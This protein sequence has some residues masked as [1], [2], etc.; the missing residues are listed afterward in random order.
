MYLYLS[1]HPCWNNKPV[2][3]LPHMGLLLLDGRVMSYFAISDWLDRHDRV[4]P[5]KL[6][7]QS[8]LERMIVMEG[9][10][11]WFTEH[12]HLPHERLIGLRRVRMVS[13][14]R[15]DFTTGFYNNRD[16]ARL[17]WYNFSNTIREVTLSVLQSIRCVQRTWRKQMAQRFRSARL[18]RFEKIRCFIQVAQRLLSNDMTNKIRD[19]YLCSS[20]EFFAE[21]KH[22]QPISRIETNEFKKLFG[23]N[24]STPI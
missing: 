23:R 13:G 5:K 20:S 15:W 18:R 12:A 11:M 1:A 3:V 17:L 8:H 9:K 19:V 6:T 16:D 22:D 7:L 24:A 4:R 21:R 14:C 2:V 10:E